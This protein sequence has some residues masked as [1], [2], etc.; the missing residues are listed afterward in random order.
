ME[1]FWSHSKRSINGTYHLISRKHAQ[2]YV[3]EFV[4]RHNTREHSN[5]ERFDLVL[6]SVMGNSYQQLTN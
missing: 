4:F 5:Q 3:D 2:K 1:N 6:G